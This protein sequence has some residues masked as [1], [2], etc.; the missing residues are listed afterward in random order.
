MQLFATLGPILFAEITTIAL[1]QS[2]SSSSMLFWPDQHLQRPRR[3]KNRFNAYASQRAARRRCGLD[4]QPGRNPG[5][6]NSDATL[7]AWSG[8]AVPPSRLRR[9]PT[10]AIPRPCQSRPPKRPSAHDDRFMALEVAPI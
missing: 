3:L 7:E 2:S 5:Y 10:L 8:T 4:S 6:V 9:R 1:V